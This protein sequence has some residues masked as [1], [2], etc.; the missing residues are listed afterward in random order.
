MKKV[1]FPQA[2]NFELIFKVLYDIGPDGITKDAISKKYKMDERQGSYYLDALLYLD[3]VE[4]Y[5]IKYFLNA[6][7]IK[8]RLTS[9]DDSKK[10]F[11]DYVLSHPFLGELYKQTQKMEQ[12]EKLE[13]I[14]AEIFNQYGLNSNTS[15]RRA[16][17]IVSWFSTIEKI[18][19]GDKNV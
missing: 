6:K 16:S 9:A 2:N 1:L 11:C 12:K 13:Y 8:I 19:N 5:N 4:K 10:V 7:G 14:S 17:S 15:A 18:I 3:V